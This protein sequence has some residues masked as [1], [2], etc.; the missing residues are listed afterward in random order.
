MKDAASLRDMRR[1]KDLQRSAEKSARTNEGLKD[2]LTDM[3]QKDYTNTLEDIQASGELNAE[4]SE[5]SLGEHRKQSTEI[6]EQ[7][8]SL[9]D[10]V[11][12]GELVAENTEISNQRLA[13]INNTL[14]DGFE[15]ISEFAQQLKENFSAQ[16]PAVPIPPSPSTETEEVIPDEEPA[17]QPALSIGDYLK[18]ISDGIVSFIKPKKEEDKPKPTS[19]EEHREAALQLVLDRLDS[20]AKVA[21]KGFNKTINI[22]D[23]IASMLFKYTVS[24]LINTAKMAALLF[25]LV[26]GVDILMIHFRHWSKLME[27]NFGEFESK[28]GS[29]SEPMQDSLTALKNMAGY[30]QNGEYGNLGS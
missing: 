16:L 19:E 8:R 26:L 2:A 29:L 6:S 13:D 18:K 23:D 24:A 21:S 20:I 25:A 10:I 14:T 7:T 4:I 5:Q 27:T 22:A 17:N 11:A 12:A 1:R 15:R 28:L 9:K 30:W 3:Q